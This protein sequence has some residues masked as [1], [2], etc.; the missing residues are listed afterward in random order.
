M[1]RTVGSVRDCRHFPCSGVVGSE[2]LEGRRL[3]PS[4]LAAY[5][6]VSISLGDA[7]EEYDRCIRMQGRGRK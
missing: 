2:G 7:T 1:N 4:P 5:R 6:S 3:A